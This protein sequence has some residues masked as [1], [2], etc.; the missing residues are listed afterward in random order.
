MDVP[1]WADLAFSPDGR[2]LAAALIAAGVDDYQSEIRV[3]DAVTGEV[4]LSRKWPEGGISTPT[5]SR[6]GMM[7]AVLVGARGASGTVK[8]LDVPT[9]KELHSLDGHR[10][11]GVL[12]LAFSPDGRRLASAAYSP[13]D[14]EAEVKLWDVSGGRELLTLPAKGRGRLAF[15]ADGHRLSYVSGVGESRDAGVKVWDATPLT[16]TPTPP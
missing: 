11:N 5:F 8:L 10:F 15:S 4:V 14:A 3:C 9:G 7:L 2:R 13:A 1:F 16:D 6:D 12:S